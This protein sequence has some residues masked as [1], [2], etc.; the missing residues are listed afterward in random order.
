[1]A[2][3]VYRT[4]NGKMLDMRALVLK[5]ENVRAVGNMKVN[6][7][8]DLLNDGNKVI[9]SKQSQLTKQYAGQVQM[10]TGKEG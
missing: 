10:R 7:R 9:R 5:N 3:N 1:M 2:G 8:G 4:A 6:A